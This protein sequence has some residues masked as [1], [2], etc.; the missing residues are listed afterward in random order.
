MPSLRFW[1]GCPSWY[2]PKFFRPFVRENAY[3]FYPLGQE[4]GWKW[5]RAVRFRRQPRHVLCRN[6]EGKARGY[7]E[8]WEEGMHNGKLT[9]I[10]EYRDCVGC[11]LG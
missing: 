3:R 1:K 4:K 8:G 11:T 9:T 10:V 6:R 5:P 2:H 7:T